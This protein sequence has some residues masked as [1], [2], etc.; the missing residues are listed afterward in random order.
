MCK[1]VMISI[2]ILKCFPYLFDMKHERYAGAIDIKL[3][4]G[5]IC[6]MIPLGTHRS[7]IWQSLLM[8]SPLPG[9]PWLL[10][11]LRH[12]KLCQ[13]QTM[14]YRWYT[15]YINGRVEQKVIYM[16][17]T[18]I[19]TQAFDYMS[20]HHT[21]HLQPYC[22]FRTIIIQDLFSIHS[23]SQYLHILAYSEGIF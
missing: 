21:K 10:L 20:V 17:E 16:A 12:V 15:P 8:A 3:L 23:F 11:L 4:L 18:N 6:E 7:Y 13:D 14:I 9:D 2:E 19:H 1:F 22:Y 5:I